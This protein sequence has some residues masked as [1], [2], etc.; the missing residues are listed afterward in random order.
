[1]SFGVSPVN[2]SDSD[3]VLET[4]VDNIIVT[5]MFIQMS[6]ESRGRSRISEEWLQM[7]KLGEGVGLV[8]LHNSAYLLLCY[9]T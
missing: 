1:M 3:S 6:G 2:Y 8:R 9:I 7:K 5:F 4:F